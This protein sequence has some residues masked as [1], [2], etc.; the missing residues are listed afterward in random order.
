MS[1]ELSR[2]VVESLPQCI[3]RSSRSV[4]SA[5]ARQLYECSSVGCQNGQIFRRLPELTV[6]RGG[7]GLDRTALR[8]RPKAGNVQRSRARGEPVRQGQD[9]GDCCRRDCSVSAGQYPRECMRPSVSGR[10]GL[11]GWPGNVCAASMVSMGARLIKREHRPRPRHRVTSGAGA[12]TS[13]HRNINTF[14]NTIL[15]TSSNTPVGACALI[16]AFLSGSSSSAA[17]TML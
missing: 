12:S 15:T 6:S 9:G 3:I 11:N 1:S 13:P 4:D 5:V 16:T 17:G 2:R 10:G 14:N 7:D 8:R